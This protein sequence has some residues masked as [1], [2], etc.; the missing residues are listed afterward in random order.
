MRKAAGVGEGFSAV[1]YPAVC[2]VGSIAGSVCQMM[3]S[4]LIAQ[5]SDSLL[6]RPT[7]AC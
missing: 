3:G 4:T 5:A 6:T 1:V 2:I 7:V